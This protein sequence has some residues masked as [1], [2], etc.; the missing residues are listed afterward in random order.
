MFDFLVNQSLNERWWYVAPF[1]II[2]LVVPSFCKFV[3]FFVAPMSYMCSNSLSITVL[4]F[5][6]S[7]ESACRDTVCPNEYDLTVVL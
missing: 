3:R 4:F 6:S 2:V 1:S 5:E 7:N